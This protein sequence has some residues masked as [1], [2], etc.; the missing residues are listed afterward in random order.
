MKK[1]FAEIAAAI[2]NS[3]ST[4]APCNRAR[5]RRK[6]DAGLPS[7]P[8]DAKGVATRELSGKV[9][10]AI[11]KS[12]PWLIGGAADLSTSTK[13]ALKFEFRRQF[14]AGRICR[15]YIN[16]GIREHA[17]GA[18]LNGLALGTA[19][20]LSARAFSSSPI[21]CGRRCGSRR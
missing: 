6:W 14:R 19:C 9:L 10:N 13:T 4:C 2:L 8:A 3:A 11:A 15:P 7:F 1:N 12:Y 21:I 18:V 5:C 16:F 20:A 17:M